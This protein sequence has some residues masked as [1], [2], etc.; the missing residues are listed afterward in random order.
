MLLSQEIATL[1]TLFARVR[2]SIHM[3]PN[4][5]VSIPLP[6]FAVVPRPEVVGAAGHR[7]GRGEEE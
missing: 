2:C 1:F 3:T 5:T 7:Q 6:E 4:N